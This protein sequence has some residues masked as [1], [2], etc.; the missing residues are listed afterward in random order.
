MKKLKKEYTAEFRK[1]D[2]ESWHRIIKL[3]QDANL[4]QTWPYDAVRYGCKGI[5]HMVVRRSTKIIASAQARLVRLPGLDKGIAYVRWGPMWRR[6][7]LQEDREIFRQ[8]IRALRN[9]FSL[10]RGLVLRVYP[11]ACRIEDDRLEEILIEEGYRINEDG[12]NERT[13]I[14]DLDLSL[15]KLRSNLHQ[16]W[17]NCLN[18]AEKNDL[19][20][21]EGEDE[22]MFDEI[23]KIYMEMVRR[24]GLVELS[25]IKH[26]RMVQRDLP[27]GLKMKVVICKLNGEI[28]AGGIFSAI[29]T[30]GIY[31]V[32][33]TSDLGLKTNGS[34]MVQWAFVNWLKEKGFCHYDLNGINPYTNPGTYRFKNRLAG[35][36]GRKVEFLGRYQ[37]EGSR[38]SSFVVNWGERLSSGSQKMVQAIRGLRYKSYKGSPEK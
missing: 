26:L 22:N 5:A 19:E 2:T 27:P 36:H 10:R 9:E 3:F 13:L 16:K 33:A 12:R 28:C 7:N 20:L 32:G 37:T 17:R 4:Y 8:S 24:K 34:Y 14:L 25:E 31:L 21:I 18:R 30:T 1:L 38:A 29:G 23:S 15:K 6:L 35:K 11:L